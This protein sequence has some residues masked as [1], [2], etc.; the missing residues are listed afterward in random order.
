MTVAQPDASPLGDMR[1]AWEWRPYQ[2]RVLDAI[3]EHLANGRLHLVAAPGAGKTSLGLEVLRRVGRPAL[4]LAPTRTIRDQWIRRLGDFLSGDEPPAWA[5]T[6]LDAPRFVTAVTY[7]A[8]HTR[9]RTPAAPDDDEGTQAEAEEGVL[10]LGTPSTDELDEVARRLVAAGVGTLVLDEAHHLRQ[11]WWKAL[12]RLAAALGEPVLVALTATPPYEGTGGQWARYEELCGPIDAEIA[13]PELVRSGTL[14]PHQDFVW[15]VEPAPDERR[16]LREHDRAV[17][18]L[19]ARLAEDPVLRAAVQQHAWVR[20]RDPDPDAVLERPELAVALLVHL[21][22]ARCRLPRGLLR[23]LDCR[24]RDLPEATLAWWETLLAGYAGVGAGN[25][26]AGWPS[27]DEVFEHRRALRRE[28]RSLG[29]L[30]RGVLRLQEAPA[31][32]AK[33][34]SSR[35]KLA[36]CRAIYRAERRCRGDALRQVVLTD[37]VRD[38]G[39]AGPAPPQLGAWPIFRAL[40]GGAAPQS[41]PDFALLT[42]RLVVVHAERFDALREALADRPGIQAEPLEA[43]PGFVRVRWSGDTTFVPAVTRLLERGAVRVVVGTRAL[44]GEGWDAPCVN[45]LVLASFV[46]SF[47]MTNQMRGRAIRS[48][49]AQPDK[50]ASLWHLVAADPGARLGGADVA[51]LERRFATFVG[52]SADGRTIASGLGRLALA[53]WR[54]PADLLASN[55]A[56]RARLEAL[57]ELGP[58]W[59]AAIER[60]EEGRVA[61][62]LRAA[63]P[64]RMRSL[65][66]WRTLR[67]LLVQASCTLVFFWAQGLRAAGLGAWESAGLVVLAVA[68]VAGLV[69]T[70]PAFFAALWLLL[71]HL[72]VDGSVRQ[73]ALALRDA[74]ARSGLVETPR[75]RLRVRTEACADGTTRVS[76][77]GGTRREQ[78]TF[79]DAL[80][81]L[82]APLRN[83]RYLVV[84]RGRLLARVRRDYHAVPT[85]LGANRERA[86][87]FARAL[88]RRIGG[89]E[90]VYTRNA[91]GRRALLRARLR[92]SARVFAAPPER[93]DRWH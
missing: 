49:G 71:R 6:D 62:T 1:F 36:A 52:L 74:L 61:P 20:A 53:R 29:L 8:L 70:L 85:V 4:V 46:G 79:V 92:A 17:D 73:L 58:A 86:G 91:D 89:I 60:G 16:L 72:P 63:R 59:R 34:L 48:D 38:E 22:A 5:G 76:L 81:E 15:A 45:S 19:L 7:Q 80:A 67:F 54:T 35:A 33:L 21:R 18:E 55:E 90:L 68:A 51:E 42:G 82:L 14:C 25:T 83:P 69:L 11:E 30:Q 78:A 84:R 75:R 44:L 9:A 57:D 64:E 32:R 2:R 23:L 28:L 41:A 66:A 56:M 31:L 3:D 65:F 87:I 37:F 50:V 77:G 39:L 47:V 13:V 93:S 40:A 24:P 26:A 27:L 10:D 12:A 43:L 88:R